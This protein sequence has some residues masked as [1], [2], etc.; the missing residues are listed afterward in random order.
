MSRLSMLIEL[1]RNGRQFTAYLPAKPTGKTATRRRGAILGVRSV[2]KLPPVNPSS[3]FSKLEEAVLT[4][5]LEGPTRNFVQPLSYLS[6]QILPNN[7]SMLNGVLRKMQEKGVITTPESSAGE[8]G[9]KLTLKGAV[10]ALY[11]SW[12]F[13]SSPGDEKLPWLTQLPSVQ[14]ST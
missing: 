7:P 5:L 12:M 4:A 8:M 1:A 10:I 14:H 13:E 2:N 9:V 6:E 3:E 11:G